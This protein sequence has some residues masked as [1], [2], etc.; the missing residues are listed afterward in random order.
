METLTLRPVDTQTDAVA[1][2]EAF[3][4]SLTAALEAGSIPPGPQL[5]SDA[6]GWFRTQVLPHREVWLAE[7]DG[8]VVGVLALDDAWLDHL[9]VL[10]PHAG[11]RIGSALLELAKGLRPAG[12]G[13]WTFVSNTPAQAFYER[14]GLVEVERTDGAGNAER[15]PDIRYAW[16]G[17]A[18]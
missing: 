10:P 11:G 16:A 7:M 12:F 2:S 17:V 13:L 14:H 8:R 4:Q 18:E 9:Y 15:S 1:A 3:A 6:T 5:P